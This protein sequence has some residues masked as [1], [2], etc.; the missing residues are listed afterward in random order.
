[1][2]TCGV[3]IKRRSKYSHLR[4]QKHKNIMEKLKYMSQ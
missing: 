3:S 1:V 2:C 4:T